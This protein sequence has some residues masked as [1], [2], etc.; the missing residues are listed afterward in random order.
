LRNRSELWVIHFWLN[1]WFLTKFLIFGE[2]FYFWRN[3]LFLTKLFI[4]WRNFCFLTK[5][6]TFHDFFYFWRNFWLLT[7]FLICDHFFSF[8]PFIFLFLN[9]YLIFWPTFFTFDKIFYFYHFFLFLTK[10]LIFD[11]NFYFQQKIDF[12][13]KFT[14]FWVSI[15]YF[16]FINTFFRL[17]ELFCC[18]YPDIGIPWEFHQFLTRQLWPYIG[19]WVVVSKGQYGNNVVGKLMKFRLFFILIL[20]EFFFRL[21]IAMKF[22][23]YV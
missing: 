10:F 16:I 3:F 14:P 23:Y 18:N 19:F 13:T 1:V 21:E 11:P 6:L 20:C 7:N 9:N 17:M 15:C 8:W 2:F 4:F 22:I 5:F 12:R